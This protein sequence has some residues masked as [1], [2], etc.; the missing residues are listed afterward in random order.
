LTELF[1]RF[2]PFDPF[3][4][5]ESIELSTGRPDWFFLPD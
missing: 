1:F 2:V 5:E 4:D 3:I